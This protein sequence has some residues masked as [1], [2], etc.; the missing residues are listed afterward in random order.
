[1]I[2]GKLT[3]ELRRLYEPSKKFGEIH[4]LIYP[5]TVCPRCYYAAWKEDFSKIPDNAPPQ[6]DTD[7]RIHWVKSAIDAELD[8]TRQRG[9]NEGLA[10]YI[11]CIMC[12]DY[13][14]EEV[15]PI[16]KQGISALRAAWLAMDIHEKQPGMNYA[17]LAKMLYRKARFFYRTAVDYE[18]NGKQS[19]GGCP[20]PGPRPGSELHV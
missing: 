7:Q 18:S 14:A 5:V 17:Y 15:S 1:M 20:N 11:L 19:I 13:H 3:A 2:A 16:L 8:F 12:Y 10:S 6:V 4:P 9:L